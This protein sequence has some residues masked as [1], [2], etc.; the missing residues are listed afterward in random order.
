MVPAT[1]ESFTNTRLPLSGTPHLESIK[2]F[3]RHL[4]DHLS[5]FSAVSVFHRRHFHTSTVGKAQVEITLLCVLNHVKN[6]LFSICR[7][8]LFLF[9][10]FNYCL[11]VTVNHV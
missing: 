11:F 6:F 7:T 2:H 10:A 1:A 9:N 3:L 5:K 8:E 4:K